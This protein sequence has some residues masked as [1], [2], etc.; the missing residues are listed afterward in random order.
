MAIATRGTTA[1]V[2]RDHLLADFMQGDY[3]PGARIHMSALEKRYE[4]SSTPI[5][6]AL[7]LLVHDGILN[8]VDGGFEVR[9]PSYAELCEMYDIRCALEGLAVSKMV[10]AG[11]S[12]EELQELR[13]IQTALENAIKDRPLQ[14]QLDQQF[15]EFICNHCG[16]PMLSRLVRQYMVL[17]TIFN[18][19]EVYMP[20]VVRPTKAAY[21][22]F[23][24]QHRRILTAIESGDPEKARRAVAHHITHTRKYFERIHIN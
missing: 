2:I 16:S 13:D 21:H 1:K 24:M 23:C 22:A 19:V 5:R 17:S 6:Q 3:H 15:H 4:V 8:Y 11:L 20:E 18:Y 14:R 7:M 9:M 12:Q 10:S